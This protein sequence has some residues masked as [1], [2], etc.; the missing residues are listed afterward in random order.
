MTS[1]AGHCSAKMMEMSYEAALL[2]AVSDERL[3]GSASH[4]SAVALH[5]HATE[6][7][8]GNP[9][10]HSP[11]LAPACRASSSSRR[12]NTEFVWGILEPWFPVGARSRNW[13]DKWPSCRVRQVAE[14]AAGVE[15]VYFW[16]LSGLEIVVVLRSTFSFGLKP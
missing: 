10:K 6:S 1:G 13:P 3:R 16:M 2:E 15:M 8:D 5:L 4:D 9:G 7:G 14:Q 11:K 12:F